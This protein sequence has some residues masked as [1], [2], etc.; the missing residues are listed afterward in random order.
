MT[1]GLALTWAQVRSLG[2]LCASGK[3]LARQTLKAHFGP[4]YRTRS[5]TVADALAAGIPESRVLMVLS[6]AAEELGG[7][8]A[9]AARAAG[10][11]EEYGYCLC[12]TCRRPDWLTVYG[13]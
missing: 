4:D 2:G 8:W 3:A 9:E 6:V 10:A 12:G 5:F 7:C 13:G 11:L 1:E